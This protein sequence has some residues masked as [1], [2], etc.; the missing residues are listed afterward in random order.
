[1]DSNFIVARLNVGILV[2]GSIVAFIEGKW[3]VGASVLVVAFAL[4]FFVAFMER[5]DLSRRGVSKSQD[6]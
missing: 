6:S 5:W 3:V 2:V 4:G 1:M